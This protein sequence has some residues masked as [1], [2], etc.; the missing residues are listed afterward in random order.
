TL[1]C[2]ASFLTSAAQTSQTFSYTGSQQSFTV[3]AF[4]T[5]VTVDVKGASGGQGMPP[6]T[7]AGGK[8]GRVQAT[9]PVN[10]GD[11]LYIYVGG[12]GADGAPPTTAGAGGFNGGGNAAMSSTTYAGGGGGGASDIRLNG[13][14]LNDRIVVAGGG[15]GG[16]DNYSTADF[17]K[18]GAGGGLTGE[19]GYGGGITPG[20]NGETGGG[21]TQSAGGNG[22]QWPSYCLSG[23]GSLGIGGNACGGMTNGTAGGGGGGGGYYGGG[24][25]CWGGGGGGSSYTA[26]SA[27]NVVHT[28]GFQ[29]GN[30]EV[31]I[32]YTITGM[33]TTLGD[34]AASVSPN[35][36]QGLFRVVLNAAGLETV[37]MQVYDVSGKA[38]YVHEERVSGSFAKELALDELGNGVYYLQA[39]T[40]LGVITEKI[41]IQK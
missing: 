34:L 9:F 30:G 31:I 6:A 29:T 16:G 17:D 23:S 3:P 26:S 11:I 28:Q 10:P 18:G 5:S 39:V 33:E 32:T 4:V 7:H 21:G 38:V 2:A 13:T 25:G 14:A 41:I 1:L 40:N 35:P 15:G 20:A 12:V 37:K 27:T 24:A 36:S 19:G 8:G 22:G